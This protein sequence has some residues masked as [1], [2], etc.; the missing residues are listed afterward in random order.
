LQLKTKDK[1]VAA[2]TLANRIADLREYYTGAQ[3]K[4]NEV[5]SVDIILPKLDKSS[6][7]SKPIDDHLEAK[8]LLK[9]SI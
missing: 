9:R 7:V 6:D 1:I 4:I 5:D 2:E 8:A 3:A